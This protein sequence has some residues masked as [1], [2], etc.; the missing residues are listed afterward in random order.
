MFRYPLLTILFI[1]PACIYAQD[2]AISSGFLSDSIKIGEPVSFGVGVRYSADIDLLFP[3]STHNFA[4]F[5]YVS[6]HWFRSQTTE[7]ITFDSII[8]SL[9]TF[10]TDSMQ[11]LR[12]PL[13]QVRYGDSTEVYTGIESIALVHMVKDL[14]DSLSK[15][16]LIE[17]T[18]YYRVE[19]LF[20]YPYFIAFS[21]LLILLTGSAWLLFGKKIIQT[22]RVNRMRKQYSTFIKKY[23]SLH[24]SL[25]EDTIKAD[26]ERLLVHWKEYMETLEGYPYLKM[27]T[28][29]LKKTYKDEKL[30]KALQG[31]DRII[32]AG[33]SDKNTGKEFEALR[34]YTEEKYLR[35]I[36]KVKHGLPD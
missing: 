34:F 15:I 35:K 17:T 11:S 36:E 27:T 28:S 31:I 13:Y 23:D 3:D 1:F 10:E 7:E 21:L 12:L 22:L 14:P 4:P 19:K 5:E 33:K 30:I 24:T 8:Y 18:D 9:R 20:N 6:R 29:E 2:L 26:S 32:Y 25:S 16:F